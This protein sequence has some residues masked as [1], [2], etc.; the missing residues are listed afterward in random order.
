[1]AD[2]LS[3][4]VEQYIGD[5]LAQG[6]YPSREALLEKAV[7]TLREVARDREQLKEALRRGID[8]IDNGRVEDWD[9]DAAVQRLDEHLKQSRS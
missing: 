3:P 6:L 9:F 4:Q 2:A 5:V 1:M 8:D 7:L